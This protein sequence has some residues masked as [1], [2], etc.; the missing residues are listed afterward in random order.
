M[1]KP[2]VRAH[3]RRMAE[4]SDKAQVDAIQKTKRKLKSQ[5]LDHIV[6]RTKWQISQEVKKRRLG[7]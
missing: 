2:K 6:A 7:K 1:K 5:R 3:N 4:L